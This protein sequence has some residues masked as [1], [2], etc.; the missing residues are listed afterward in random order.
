MSKSKSVCHEVSVVL[1]VQS[2][3]FFWLLLSGG[4]CP[5]C[6]AGSLPALITSAAIARA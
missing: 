2:P 6:A 4:Y 3:C 1:F 5:A